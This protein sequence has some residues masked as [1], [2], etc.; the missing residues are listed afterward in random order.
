[1]YLS[2]KSLQPKGLF[3]RLL[4]TSDTAVTSMKAICGHL[5]LDFIEGMQC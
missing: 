1:M 4:G 5:G 2:D 3:I